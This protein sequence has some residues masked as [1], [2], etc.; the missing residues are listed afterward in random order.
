MTQNKKHKQAI[1]LLDECI[2]ICEY[3]E[4]S[5]NLKKFRQAKDAIIQFLNK[6]T[7]KKAENKRKI[8]EKLRRIEERQKDR[9]DNAKTE[10]ESEE[11]K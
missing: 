8:E 3:M 5:E 1:Q 11:I 6:K 4:K 10:E 7:E 2:D 9:Q